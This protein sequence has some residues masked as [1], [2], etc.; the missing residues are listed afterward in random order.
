[1][2]GFNRGPYGGGASGVVALAERVQAM[3]RIEPYA[4]HWKNAGIKFCETALTYGLVPF[5]F[6]T[7]TDTVP[8]PT[9]AV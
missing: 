4:P 3:V 8:G 7:V 6:L 5:A 1:M 2:V 9:L